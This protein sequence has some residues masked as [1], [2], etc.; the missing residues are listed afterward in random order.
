MGSHV[1]TLGDAQ[2]DDDRIIGTQRPWKIIAGGSVFLSNAL[3]VFM[4]PR[5]T[6]SVA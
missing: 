2:I 3:A 4:K 1:D 5:V 6:S